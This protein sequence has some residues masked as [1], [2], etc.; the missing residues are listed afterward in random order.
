MKLEDIF[1]KS[2]EIAKR[3]KAEDTADDFQKMAVKVD[4]MGIKGPTFD[5]YLEILN[6]PFY[7]ETPGCLVLES[8]SIPK[9]LSKY[10]VDSFYQGVYVAPPPLPTHNIPHQEKKDPAPIAGS[11]FCTKIAPCK[12][13]PP[14]RRSRLSNLKFLSFPIKKHQPKDCSYFL[15]PPVLTTLRQGYLN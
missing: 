6:K 14:F 9:E 4:A 1:N 2:L 5:Q 11:F 10:L 13:L 12:R 8:L 7:H 15:I 3:I